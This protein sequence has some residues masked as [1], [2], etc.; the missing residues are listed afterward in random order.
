[1]RSSV[2]AVLALGGNLGERENTIAT[3]ITQ[4][5]AHKK[6]QVIRQSP[7]IESTALTEAGVDETKPNYLNGVVEIRTSLRP[8]KLLKFVSEIENSH[9][10]IRVERWGSRTLDIDII[11]YGEVFKAGK[12]LTIPH[13]RAHQRAF[14]LVP[15]S[16]MDSDAILPGH[17]PV[18]QLAS[19][20]ENQIWLPK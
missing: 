17:G 18:S 15:W 1:M 2:K 20:M 6:V 19:G 12:K 10:R 5:D 13:P 8:K 16:M 3:A 4:L 14:V 11:T 9:G 7:L